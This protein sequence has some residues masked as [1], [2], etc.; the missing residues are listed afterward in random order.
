MIRKIK[1]ARDNKVNSL[2]FEDRANAI[3][4]KAVCKKYSHMLIIGDGR[5]IL[6]VYHKSKYEN[7][8]IAMFDRAVIDLT[9]MAMTLTV[10]YGQT[11]RIVGRR[12][13]INDDEFYFFE[14]DY[15]SVVR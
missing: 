7:V 9:E 1:I 15:V 2:I 4:N 11:R 14:S 8:L 6:S 12:K 3:V 5:A 13:L 10:N